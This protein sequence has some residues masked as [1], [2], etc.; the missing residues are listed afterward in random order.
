MN[1]KS[2]ITKP[3]FNIEDAPPAI[4]EAE[5][6]DIYPDLNHDERARL[7][8]LISSYRVLSQKV[9]PGNSLSYDQ[10]VEPKFI[11]ENGRAPENRHEVR[12]AMNA[13]PF[14]SLWGSLRRSLMEV[15]QMTGQEVVLRQLET[16]AHKAANLNE[17]HINLT[18][19]NK[20]TIPRYVGEIDHHCMPGSYYRE[21]VTGDVSPAANYDMGLFVTTSGTIGPLND[22]GGRAIANWLQTDYPDFKPKHILDIGVA[23]GH[24]LFGLAKALP[25]TK[26]TAID[27]SAPMLRY[28]A[29][30]AT[31]LG[32]NNIEFVQASGEDLSRFND[33]DFDIVMT[34]IFLHELS[35]SALPKLLHEAYRLLT[36]KGLM[37]HLEQPQYTSDMSVYEQFIRDWDAYNNNEPFW[38]SMHEINLKELMVELGFDSQDIFQKALKVPTGSGAKAQHQKFE[39]HGRSP[40]WN[41][42]GAWKKTT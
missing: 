21:F 16:L 10:V 11:K 32:L 14:H 9:A 12:K 29:A 41:A 3:A 23:V 13:N 19:D 1:K 42:Y 18:L 6:H 20:I 8:F 34:S 33:D 28:A 17:T 26:F 39:E 30:R 27:V 5:R 24:S 40:A 31:S 2:P 38:S 25:D 35:G 22:G 36:N 7:N 15:R 4:T 37:L